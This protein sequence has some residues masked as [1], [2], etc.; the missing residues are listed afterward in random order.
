MQS[1]GAA[2]C[3]ALKAECEAVILLVNMLQ[4]DGD[5]SE[6]GVQFSDEMVSRQADLCMQQYVVKQECHDTKLS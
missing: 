2:E 5:D 3:E 4:E 1:A 6:L